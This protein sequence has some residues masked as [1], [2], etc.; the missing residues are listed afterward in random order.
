MI[1]CDSITI[2][3]DSIVTTLMTSPDNVQRFCPKKSRYVTAESVTGQKVCQ[4]ETICRLYPQIP[5][6]VVRSHTYPP[7]ASQKEGAA[8]STE[9][10]RTTT[11]GVL[12]RTSMPTLL[13]CCS[14]LFV[15]A[16]RDT[17]IKHMLHKGFNS[18]TSI[19]GGRCREAIHMASVGGQ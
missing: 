12:E 5:A 10:T 17:S 2:V 15:V 18:T 9:C 4:R 13:G 3:R 14:F 8:S 19:N 16:S 6:N 7:Q 11:T 1:Y